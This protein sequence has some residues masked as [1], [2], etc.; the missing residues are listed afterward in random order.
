MHE[1]GLEVVEVVAVFLAVEAGAVFVDAFEFVV[2][3]DDGVGVAGFQAAEQGDESFALGRGAGVGCVASLVEA[4]FVADADGVGIVVEGMHA[5][6]AFI[7]SLVEAAVALD[8]VVIAYALVVE[9]GV[10][11]FPEPLDG[12]ALVAAGGRAVDDDEVDF[13]HDRSVL[14]GLHT[15]L[16]EVGAEDG[17]EDGYDDLE[18]LFDG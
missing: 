5:D 2:A 9:A 1:R 18:Q 10:V 7:A 17:G 13:A 12:E 4:A 11:T 16:D 15:A 3:L 14:K 6:L 8:V